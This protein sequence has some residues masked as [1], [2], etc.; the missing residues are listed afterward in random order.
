MK[1][2]QRTE[3]VKKE[4]DIYDSLATQKNACLAFFGEKKKY[5]GGQ[6]QNESNRNTKG[7]E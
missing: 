7:K 3:K 4:R 1:M 5:N 2:G 6:K